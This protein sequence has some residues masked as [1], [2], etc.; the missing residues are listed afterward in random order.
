MKA[1]TLLTSLLGYG[2]LISALPAPVESLQ[3]TVKRSISGPV[4][5]G[6]N[7]PDPTVIEVGGVWY[8][9]ATRTKGS[10]IHIQ[11]ATSSDFENWS[12]VKN[13]DGS[14]YDALPTLPPW[15]NQQSWNTWAPSITQIVRYIQ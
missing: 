1:T 14:Q 6:A 15:V 10:T 9:F 5:S 11:A 8:A 12:L 2:S 3:A 7:F 4:L 13:A